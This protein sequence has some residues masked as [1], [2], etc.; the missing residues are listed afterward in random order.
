MTDAWFHNAI[1]TD[2]PDGEGCRPEEALALKPYLH[3]LHQHRRMLPPNSPLQPLTFHL[4]ANLSSGLILGCQKYIID[5]L[6]KIQQLSNVE[7]SEEQRKYTLRDITEVLCTYR[8]DLEKKY[9]MKGIARF[10]DNSKDSTAVVDIEI[11]ILRIRIHQAGD[12]IWQMARDISF[13]LS[14]EGFDERGTHKGKRN[15]WQGGGRSECTAVAVL[16]KEGGRDGKR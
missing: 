12:L 8:A 3:S 1:A 16:E 7:L 15:P 4:Q 11:S 5:L 10:C 13:L 2:S 14:G 9:A 6:L